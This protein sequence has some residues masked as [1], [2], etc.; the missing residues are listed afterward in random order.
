MSD[1]WLN[2]QEL[3]DSEGS[4]SIGHIEQI[5]GAALATQGHQVHAQLRIGGGAESLGDILDRL[6]T[7]VGRFFEDGI[8]IDEINL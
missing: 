2:L 1:R 7:V 8:V 5:G 6:D 4:I 3:I